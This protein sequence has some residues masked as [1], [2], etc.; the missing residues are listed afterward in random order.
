M[1]YA[2]GA[3]LLCMIPLVWLTVLTW[4]LYTK[5]HDNQRLKIEN[6]HLREQNLMLKRYLKFETNG[7]EEKE[8]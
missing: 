7:E 6:E 3:A 1:E 2:V 4:K 8:D 5:K